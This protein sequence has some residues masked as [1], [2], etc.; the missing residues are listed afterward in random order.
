MRKRENVKIR[1]R[2]RTERARRAAST[3]RAGA[4]RRGQQVEYKIN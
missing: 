1:T 3:P 2:R 4:R